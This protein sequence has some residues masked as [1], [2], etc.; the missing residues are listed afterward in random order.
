MADNDKPWIIE[1][2]MGKHVYPDKSFATFQDARDFISEL[3]NAEVA[4]QVAKG[5]ITTEK[6][7]EDLYNGVCEDLFAVDSTREGK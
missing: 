2:W 7:Q 3:A 4:E 1:T 6:E 5:W